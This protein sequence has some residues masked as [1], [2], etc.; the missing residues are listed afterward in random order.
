MSKT[1]PPFRVPVRLGLLLLLLSAS[2]I[3]G[4]TSTFHRRRPRTGTEAS[5]VP[6]SCKPPWTTP[7]PCSPGDTIWLRGGIYNAPPYT[8]HLVGTSAN[9]IIVRQY[10]GERARI[11]GNYNGNEPTLTI[12]GKYAWF[13]DFE[14][15]N[16]DPTRFSPG[17]GQPPRRGTGV[18]LSGDGTRMINMVI[19]D[20]SQG[21]LVSEAATDARVYGTLFYYNGYGAP[22]R[23]HGH[24]VYAQNLGST[25]KQIYDNLI[26]QQFGWGIHAYGEGG[27]LD[28]FDFQGNISF[29]NGG[30]SGNWHANILVGG[31]QYAATNPKLVSNYTYN[32]DYTS[33]N[34]CRLCRRLHLAGR[35]QQLFRR[36]PVPR[37]QRLQLVADHRQLVRRTDLGVFRVVLPE[38]YL[39]RLEPAHRR[40]GLRPSQRL[41]VRARQHRD[42]QLGPARTRSP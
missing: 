25:T 2:T 24:G 15:F 22:D 42:L 27:H 9:P 13:W 28:N 1:F 26:F 38:Q 35:H 16:S 31:M 23:G 8:S 36:Q 34:R 11:D 10:P 41:R 3:F 29:N 6:G 40:E 5:T 14:I 4:A 39:L 18:Q 30:L 37:H 20:T 19:H 21:V 32:E 12:M 33:K 17:G 7:P